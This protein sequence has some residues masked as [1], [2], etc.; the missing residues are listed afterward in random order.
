MR[1]SVPL[2]AR[3]PAS[4]PE[5]AVR[6]ADDAW[7]LLLALARLRRGQALPGSETGFRFLDDGTV[8]AAADGDAG[9]AARWHPETGWSVPGEHDE[10]VRTLLDL[11]LPMCNAQPRSPFVVAHLGQSID[12]RIAT[13]SGDSRFVTG[14]RNRRH[15]HRLR[16]L[17]D[18]V[19]VGAGTIAA[20]DPQLTTRL[21]P[22]DD[23]VRIVLDPSFRSRPEAGVLTDRRAPT[24][25]AVAAARVARIGTRAGAAEI[26][27]TPCRD[28]NLDLHALLS[29]LAARGLHALFIEGGGVT[30]S[31]F[32]E[33]GLIDTL[34]IAVAP[35]IIGSGRAGLQLP[36][37]PSMGD[38]LRPAVHVFRMGE[39]I[40]WSFDLRS[41]AARLAPADAPE[42]RRIR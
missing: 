1:Q 24:I 26:V 16:A 12:G 11:Y 30:V 3:E 6:S 35:V 13:D 27:A 31:Q 5:R 42:L 28:G 8:E 29:I 41:S 22:G 7:A 23:P 39:D 38:C 14:E 25:L 32:L 19:I 34:Q 2:F 33:A 9:I 17:S 10:S 20:D 37:V 4:V 18:A 40:L 21:V 36:A 15:L